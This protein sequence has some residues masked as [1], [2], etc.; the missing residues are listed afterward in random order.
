MVM[1]RSLKRCP[2]MIA[3]AAIVATLLAGNGR[4]AN[5]GTI[6]GRMAQMRRAGCCCPTLP[7][8]GCCCEPAATSAPSDTAE[9]TKKAVAEISRTT[10]ALDPARSGG[11][12]RCR[13]ND[14]VAP[15]PQPFGRG[16][17]RGPVHVGAAIVTLSSQDEIAPALVRRPRGPT[18]SLQKSPIYLRTSHLLI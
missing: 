6:P 12:C 9:R 15:T 13:S 14:P 1:S 5:A 17:D 11:N 4:S 18:P 10:D 3:L 8:G 2:W 7:V 16:E